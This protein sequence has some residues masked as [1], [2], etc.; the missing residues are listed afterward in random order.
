MEN[1][2]RGDVCVINDGINEAVLSNKEKKNYQLLK[3]NKAVYYLVMN[4][5]EDGT[6]VL[7]RIYKYGRKDT[8]QVEFY[9]QEMW[10]AY[11]WFLNT[12]AEFLIHSGLY[13][14]NSR[15]VVSI[16]YNFHNEFKIEWDL[17]KPERIAKS[18]EKRRKSKDIQYLWKKAFANGFSTI[19]ESSKSSYDPGIAKHYTPDRY[20][21]FVS[22]GGVSPR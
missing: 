19:K 1:I 21:R 10:I 8:L 6:V 13:F 7:T 4:T 12:K 9:G 22:G 2:K 20:V 11:G 5:L 16:I 17:S 3:N 18:I 15:E 14:E